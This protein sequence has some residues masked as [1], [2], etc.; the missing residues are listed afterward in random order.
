M[1]MQIAPNSRRENACVF[2]PQRDIPKKAFHKIR[3]FSLRMVSIV[4]ACTFIV[5]PINNIDIIKNFT[6]LKCIFLSKT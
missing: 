2:I 4:C 6:I 1:S 3:F 5:S